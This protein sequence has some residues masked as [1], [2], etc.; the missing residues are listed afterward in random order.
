MKKYLEALSCF[1]KGFG[2][3]ADPWIQTDAAVSGLFK[4]RYES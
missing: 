3:M 1:T 2:Q 4:A